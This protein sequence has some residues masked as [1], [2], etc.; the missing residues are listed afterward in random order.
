[1]DRAAIR[2]GLRADGGPHCFLRGV[3]MKKEKQK[4]LKL[5]EYSIRRNRTG[6]L[7]IAPAV[8]AILLLSVYPLLNGILISFLN[9]DMTKATAPEFGT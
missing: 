5:E 8:I 4:K 9:Y 2:L 6:Y 7:L 3:P 1:M